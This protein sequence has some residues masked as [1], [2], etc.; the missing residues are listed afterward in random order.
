M[1]VIEPARRIADDEH[2]E[3]SFAADYDDPLDD[4]EE[5]GADA[6]AVAAQQ[7]PR[8]KLPGALVLYEF[9]CDQDSMLGKVG[10]DSGIQVVRL[11]KEQIDLE[12][13]GSI[14]Q[15]MDQVSA[16]PRCAL[17]GALECKSWSAWSRLNAAKHPDYLQRLEEEREQSRKLCAEPIPG[18]V[19][20]KARTS[21]V[22]ISGVTET[23]R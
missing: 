23:V 20:V 8:H 19:V 6:P 5:E 22:E 4:F 14:E 17:H 2:Y 10:K 21:G 15:L 9:C 1:A 11:C 12:A 7:I 16:T 3:P 13:P 18:R